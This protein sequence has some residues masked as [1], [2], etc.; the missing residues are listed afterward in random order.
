MTDVHSPEQRSRNMAAIKYKDTRP[1]IYVRKLIHS[2]GFRYRLHDKDLPGKPDLVF[3]RLKKVIFVHGCYWHMHNCRFG[4]VSPKTNAA[5]WRLK[6]ISNV[7]R[8]RRNITDLKRLGWSPYIVWEC[9]IKDRE[10]LLVKLLYF[11]TQ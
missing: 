2:I 4:K 1:E 5:F 11:L 6:R 3:A 7:V 8:D 10:K 9:Q